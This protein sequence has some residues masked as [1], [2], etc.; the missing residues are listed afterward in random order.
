MIKKNFWVVGLVFCVLTASIVRAAE[1]TGDGTPP[2]VTDVDKGRYLAIAG[3]CG[4]CHTV[5][6]ERPFAGGRPIN[7]PFGIIYTSN[8]TPD[9]QTGI[10]TWT[11]QDFAKAMREGL[12]PDGQHLY[13]AF[14]YTAF[15]KLSDQDIAFLFAYLRTLTPIKAEPISNTLSFPFNKRVLMLVWNALFFK[16]G[17]FVADGSKSAD[18]NR[19]AYLVEGL[20]HCGACHTPRNLLGAE[21]ADG[22]L[23]GGTYIDKVPGDELKTWSTVNLTPDATGLGAWS[24]DAIADF[25]QSGHNARAVTFGPMNDVIMPSTRNLSAVD[26][27]AMAAYLKSLAP[28]G[29]SATPASKEE[30]DADASVYTLRCGTCHE[31]TGL[32]SE[33][34]GPP[35]VGSA[36]VQAP[37]PSSLINAILYGTQLPEP[38]PKLSYDK[39][40]TAMGDDMTDEDIAKV[41]TY[42]RGNWGNRAGPVSDSQVVKQH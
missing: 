5:A 9:P 8:I 19:G 32:G 20:G 28:N 2:L 16:Q 22:A 15:T 26:V 17:R 21:K 10:G 30:L 31:P 6:E 35:L 38:F 39:V 41:A 34:T 27:K 1:P 14:P 36:I 12:R 11:E 40:M 42:V 3:N 4:N 23:T 33:A 13:P 29:Q 25:L 7:T 18:W 37:D 24:L